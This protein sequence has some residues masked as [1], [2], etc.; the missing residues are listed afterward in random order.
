MV[1]ADWLALRNEQ[2]RLVLHPGTPGA[3]ERQV[4]PTSA[5]LLIGPEVPIMSTPL[6]TSAQPVM[7]EGELAARR[8]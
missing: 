1:L 3:L 5:V 7:H 2:L 4:T 8:V 6:G